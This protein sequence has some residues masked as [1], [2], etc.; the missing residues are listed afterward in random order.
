MPEKVVSSES[1]VG[2]LQAHHNGIGIDINRSIYQAQFP[3]VIE[4]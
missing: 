4:E 2:R 1:Y 3:F